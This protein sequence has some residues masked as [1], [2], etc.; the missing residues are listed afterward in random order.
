M[1]LTPEGGH[2]LYSENDYKRLVF[3][4]RIRELGF[5]LN[6]IRELLKLVDEKT[7]TCAEIA[8]LSQ[9]HL[10]DIGAKIKDLRKIERHMKDM[11]SQCSREKVPECAIL[12]ILFKA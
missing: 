12:D 5:S 6:E 8:T 1:G 3:V 9:K 4:R 7:F 10:D 2:R 11:L